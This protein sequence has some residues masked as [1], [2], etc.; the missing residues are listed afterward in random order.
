MVVP[1]CQ[2]QVPA[3]KEQ[4]LLLNDLELRTFGLFIEFKAEFAGT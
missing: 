1:K 2:K 3:K 4:K